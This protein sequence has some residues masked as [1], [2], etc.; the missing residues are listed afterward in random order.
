[1]AD[2]DDRLAAVLGEIRKRGGIGSQPIPD[3]IAHSDRFARAC[4]PGAVVGA[5]LGSGGGLPALVVAVRHPELELH[6]VERRATRADLLRYGVAAL[7]L[8]DRVHVHVTDVR[9]FASGGDRFDVVMARSF[10]APAATVM[11]AAALARP[12]GSILVSASPDDR[13]IRNA[14][15]TEVGVVDEG[16]HDGIHRYRRL[17]RR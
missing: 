9:T 13:P 14:L 8:D 3:A 15:L 4:P 11:A 2:A 6:L 12:G 7:G 17:Q 5:D 1:M 10:A 16:V